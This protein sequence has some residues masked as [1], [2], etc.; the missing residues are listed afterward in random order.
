MTETDTRSLVIEREMPHPPEKVW[1]LCIGGGS[2]GSGQESPVAQPIGRGSSG[3]AR[4]E[5]AKGSWSH[6]R[7]GAELVSER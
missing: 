2:A 3:A 7:R 6:R 5:I 1:R 4:T